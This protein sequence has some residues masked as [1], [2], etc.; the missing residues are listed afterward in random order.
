MYLMIYSKALYNERAAYMLYLGFDQLQ[1]WCGLC[2]RQPDV[3]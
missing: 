3:R 1:V 2:Q